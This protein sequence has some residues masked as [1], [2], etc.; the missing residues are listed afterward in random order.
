[1]LLRDTFP[2]L[3]IERQY[4][5]KSDLYPKGKRT[6]DFAVKRNGHLIAIV[7]YDGL[8]HFRPVRFSKAM[9]QEQA[10]AKFVLQQ[11]VDAIDDEFCKKE[12]LVLVR[13]KYNDDLS[14]I[15]AKLTLICG[16]HRSV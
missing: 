3:D 6:F 13:V 7:E 1:V 16:K 2:S 10:N 9:S 8:Q 5:V 11:Q 12:G 15:N 14:T 4:R